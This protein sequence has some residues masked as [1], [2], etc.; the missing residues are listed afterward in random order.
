ML[1][2]VLIC[3]LNSKFAQFEFV[4]QN[5]LYLKEFHL[6]LLFRIKREVPVLHLQPAPIHQAVFD[7]TPPFSHP[8][9]NGA[10]VPVV[11]DSRDSVR[12]YHH[13]FPVQSPEV[14]CLSGKVAVWWPKQLS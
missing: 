4:F 3:P 11:A 12:L 14:Q 13:P 9:G 7:T 2:S 10:L 5:L 8:S 6:V 1:I